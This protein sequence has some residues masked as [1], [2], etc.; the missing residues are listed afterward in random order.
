MARSKTATAAASTRPTTAP[1]KPA[2]RRSKSAGAVPASDAVTGAVTGEGLTD[3][4]A[5]IVLRTN[6]QVVEQDSIALLHAAS[7]L[8]EADTPEKV[9]VAL[10]YNLRLWVA[11]KSVLQGEANTL[12]PEVKANLRNL[13]SHVV[14]TTMEATTGE[15]ELRR[16][17]NLSRINMHIAEGLLRGQ[18]NKMVQD[19]AYEIWEREGR[20]EGRDMEHWLQ[21]EAEISAMLKG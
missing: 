6:F 12:S 16:L 1:K 5:E 17:I 18:Q 11:I 10:D 15:I 13:A 21:A 4:G 8:V 14:N 2:P 20:P 9:V 3:G 19:R 7:L